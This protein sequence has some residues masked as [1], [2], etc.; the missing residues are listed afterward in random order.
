M[1]KS[2]LALAVLGVFASAAS[3]QSSV[4]LS[5]GVDIG[6]I[7]Q[8]PTKNW[9]MGTSGSSASNFSL[10]GTEDLGGGMKAIFLL[11]HRFRPNTGEIN[12][13]GNVAGTSPQYFW[14]QSWVG[15]A[16]GFGDVRLG[17]ILM[18]LQDFNGGF[19]PWGGGDT[20]GSIHTGGPV[21]T[22]RATNSIYYR[23]PSMGGLQLHAAIGAAEGQIPAECG[24]CSPINS[25]RP[26]GLGLRYDAGPLSAAIA[27]D[28]NT[29][30][31]DTVGLYGKYNFGRALV[32]GQYEKSEITSTIDDNRFSISADV[33]F[34]AFTGK[35][36]VLRIKRDLAGG[37]DATQTKLGLGLWYALSKRTSLYTDMG[38]PSGDN[39]ATGANLTSAQKRASFDLGIRHK[40]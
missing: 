10:S 33:P 19:E 27:Y 32:Y 14:R 16:G 2:L 31:L 21:A 20:V 3:A 26:V 9:T 1:K 37:G 6:V 18:P 7:Y 35:V 28:R 24:G 25:E 29:A 34:G 36:G 12:V 13:A 38:K 11:N 39:L 8:G 22:V 23:S 4:T 30:D 40:F 15:L 17:R 5:G